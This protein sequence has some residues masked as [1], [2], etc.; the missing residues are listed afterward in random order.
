[1]SK[2]EKDKIKERYFRGKICLRQETVTSYIG[3]KQQLVKAIIKNIN[4]FESK[5]FLNYLKGCQ[6]QGELTE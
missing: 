1:M 6:S 2:I 5:T 4:F 3:L